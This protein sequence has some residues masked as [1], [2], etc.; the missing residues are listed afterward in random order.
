MTLARGL[1]TVGLVMGLG[2]PIPAAAAEQRE[3]RSR[4]GRSASARGGSDAGRVRA[5]PAQRRGSTDATAR[6]TAPRRTAQPRTAQPRRST[7][8]PAAR[9]VQP[10]NVRPDVVRADRYRASRAPVVV[11]RNQRRAPVRVV[12]YRP[13]WVRPSWPY[14]GYGRPYRLA[15]PYYAF[16]PRVSVG[17]G[18]WVGFPVAYPFYGYAG[19]VVTPVPY[20]A[21]YPY[22]YPV[23]YP[24]PAPAPAQQ[25]GG[26]TVAPGQADYG[27]VSFE[28]TPSD[29]EIYVDGDYAGIASE[30]SPTS[31]PLTLTPGPHT[32]EV[33]AAGHRTLVFEV[34][35][36]PGHVIPY[37]GA[38]NPGP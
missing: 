34:T 20:P 35:I 1:V 21:P 37:R 8:A 32:I 11:V 33:R 10:R 13:G 25:P 9:V 28:M 22:P 36:A 23:P 16:R 14:A 6:Q 24:V 5:A 27:G 26:I 4:E 38:L 15:R 31:Q 12:G 17:V 7:A 30:F 18:L 3:G 2:V 29:A 19:P